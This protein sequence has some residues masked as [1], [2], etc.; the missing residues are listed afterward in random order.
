MK[1]WLVA[2]AALGVV[3]SRAENPPEKLVEAGIREF[4]RAY[5][6]WD[7]TGFLAA[8]RLFQQAADADP[9]SATHFY[10]LGV[11]H[12]HRVLHLRHRPAPMADP[13][14]TRA[15]MD[16]A[17]AALSRAVQ[18]DPRQAES[19]ALLGTVY[20][21][22]IEGNLV[23]AVR[24]GPRIEKHRKAALEY[25]PD[26]PRVRYLLGTCQFH[27]A[28]RPAAWREALMTLLAAEKRFAAE[29]QR[30]SGP[31]EPRW[32]YASCLTFIGRTYEQLGQRN[33]AA[34]YFRRAVALQPSNHLA[35]AGLARLGN[36][37]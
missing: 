32:G 8:A 35:R 16:A 12:F 7:D 4:T 20:G 3:L 15:A 23:R 37:P 14:E 10:W 24:F 31:L 25:G 11:V 29:A 22:K 13:A 9:A 21:M 5:E 30:P 6:A 26:N 33:E 17:Q 28:K 2:I 27:T 36:N 18:L 19:H 1:R 34:E